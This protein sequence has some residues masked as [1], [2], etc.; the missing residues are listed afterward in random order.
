MCSQPGQTDGAELRHGQQFRIYSGVRCLREVLQQHLND[1]SAEYFAFLCIKPLSARMRLSI[2][3][4]IIYI[5]IPS[6]SQ[7]DFH[8]TPSFR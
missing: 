8:V 3:W 4:Y 6:T 2:L 7:H 1:A 5:K